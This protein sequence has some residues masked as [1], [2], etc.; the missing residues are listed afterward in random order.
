MAKAIGLSHVTIGRIWQ[1]FGLKPHRTET[2]KLSPDPLLIEKVAT[3]SC[4][5]TQETMSGA[6]WP[7]LGWCELPPAPRAEGT[8]PTPG[9]SAIFPVVR[10]QSAPWRQHEV[11]VV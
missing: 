9:P 5:E 6:A 10:S 4:L 7:S 2:F 8:S 3:R 1:T 11:F